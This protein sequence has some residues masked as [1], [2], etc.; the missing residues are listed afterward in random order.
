MCVCVYILNCVILRQKFII[1]T[2]P[3]KKNASYQ[4]GCSTPHSLGQGFHTIGQLVW[5][6]KDLFV[7]V[8]VGSHYN[9]KKIFT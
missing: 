4:Y 6:R 7:I 2:S 9:R 1:P 3:S 5:Q 8:S